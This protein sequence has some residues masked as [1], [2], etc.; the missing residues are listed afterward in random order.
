M[1]I[2]Y[3]AY[4]E[5]AIFKASNLIKNSRTFAYSSAPDDNQKALRE[6]HA[7][8][9]EQITALQELRSA[10]EQLCQAFEKANPGS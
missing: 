6:M 2:D 10:V 5:A 4:A 9:E 7:A 8:A 1:K 3:L